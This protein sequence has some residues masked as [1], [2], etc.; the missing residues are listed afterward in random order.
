MNNGSRNFSTAQ[1]SMQPER[2]CEQ[3]PDTRTRERDEFD[4][5]LLG[6]IENKRAVFFVACKLTEAARIIQRNVQPSLLELDSLSRPVPQKCVAHDGDI[7]RV[8]VSGSSHP[9]YATRHTM[10]RE[11]SPTGEEFAEPPHVGILRGSW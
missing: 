8:S 1:V 4:A 6:A 11:T 9:A 7:R 3:R 5:G 2:L 10:G